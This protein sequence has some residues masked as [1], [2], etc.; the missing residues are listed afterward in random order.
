MKMNHGGVRR[1]KP[2]SFRYEY[3]NK[4]L[5][6]PCKIC[7][8]H[9]SRTNG[10]YMIS[11][12]KNITT[13][14]RFIYEEKHGEL[15][16]NIVVRHRCDN[17][18]CCEITHLEAGTAQDNTND[19]LEQNRH[20]KGE[21]HPISKLS[22]DDVREIKKSLEGYRPNSKSGIIARLAEKYN[23][24]HQTIVLIRKGINWKH[25]EV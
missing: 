12:G 17:R 2:L 21:N 18:E 19:M 4:N 7:I 25:V 1:R 6:T 9:K 10:Y 22:E 16:D 3:V 15:Q 13:L 23:V 20:S 14:H 24:H 5:S 11:N 8:S